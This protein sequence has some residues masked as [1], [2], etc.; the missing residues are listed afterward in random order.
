MRYRKEIKELLGPEVLPYLNK[1]IEKGKIRKE[2]LKNLASELELMMIYEAYINKVPFDGTVANEMFKDILDKWYENILFKVA[3]PRDSFLE[4]LKE[5]DFP[6]PIL[7]EL[8]SKVKSK[9]EGADQQQQRPN[10]MAVP[11]Q[12]GRHLAAADYE[13]GLRRRWGGGLTQLR[14][15]VKEAYIED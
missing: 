12:A 8:Q 11:G 4:T 2:M 10:L 15:L 13:A 3:D 14:L 7:D 1:T 6:A 5:A 9:P